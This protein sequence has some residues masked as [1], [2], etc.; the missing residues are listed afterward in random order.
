MGGLTRTLEETATDHD[1][2]IDLE[3]GKDD[4][5]L[6]PTSTYSEVAKFEHDAMAPNARRAMFLLSQ[7]QTIGHQRNRA[8][9]SWSRSTRIVRRSLN[10]RPG[11]AR[12]LETTSEIP[13]GVFEKKLHVTSSNARAAYSEPPEAYSSNIKTPVL[14]IHSP[15]ATA[16]NDFVTGSSKQ[17]L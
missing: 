3:D 9:E 4:D 7:D 10:R 5:A 15:Q 6:Y 1:F 17:K 2:L 8:I 16:G 13:V 12:N 11:A 14:N